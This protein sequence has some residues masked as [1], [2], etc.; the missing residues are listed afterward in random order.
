VLFSNPGIFEHQVCLLNKI[1][2]GQFLYMKY[3]VGIRKKND[4][5]STTPIGV[6]ILIWALSKTKPISAI[7]P[8]VRAITIPKAVGYEPFKHLPSLL[9]KPLSLSKVTLDDLVT[10]YGTPSIVSQDE[11]MKAPFGSCLPNWAVIDHPTVIPTQNIRF[12]K[13]S[14]F[15]R[16]LIKFIISPVHIL[17]R[18]VKLKIIIFILS[19]I[20]AKFRALSKAIILSLGIFS[21]EGCFATDLAQLIEKTEQEY[22][23][24]KG[25]LAAITS[26][27]SGN[28]PYALNISGKSVIASSKDEAI[29]IVHLYKDR[30]VSNID[31]G[32][33]QINL[34]WHG[35]H[36]S[37]ISEML[38]PKHNIEYAAK[39]LRLL[40]AQHDSWNKAVKHYHSANPQYHVKYSRKV[41]VAWLDS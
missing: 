36:F 20:L 34:R 22:A 31:L 19:L 16:D 41:L 17:M 21:V 4:I 5:N 29:K 30:G 7:N 11:M 27:E 3:K 8:I 10:I 1:E 23:I 28:K 25:L 40:Y 6:G 14:L 38:E 12:Q 26:V 37:S 32:M 9:K 24:P 15:S 33:A 39:F 2:I 18:I 13:L 35:K